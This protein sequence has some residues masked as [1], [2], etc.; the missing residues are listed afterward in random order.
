[1]EQVEGDNSVPRPPRPPFSM[2]KPPVSP[3]KKRTGIA[4]HMLSMFHLSAPDLSVDDY[5][6]PKRR[7]SDSAAIYLAEAN[8]LIA[9]PQDKPA[10]RMSGNAI[11]NIFKSK[12]KGAEAEGSANGDKPKRRNSETAANY[13]AQANALI[14]EPEDKPARRMVIGKLFKS[15]KKNIEAEDKRTREGSESGKTAKTK[16][17][18]SDTEGKSDEKPPNSRGSGSSVSRRGERKLGKETED[19]LIEKTPKSRGSGGSVSRRGE[20]KLGK[21]TEDDSIEK[22]SKGKRSGSRRKERKLGKETDDGSIENTPKSKKSAISV[23]CREDRKLGKETDD[24]SIE[25]TPKSKKSGFS[26]S[27]RGE[28]K[29]GKEIEDGS[30]GKIPTS[31][32]SGSSKEIQRERGT[33]D[34]STAESPKPQRNSGIG[35]DGSIRLPIGTPKSKRKITVP[36]ATAKSKSSKDGDQTTSTKKKVLKNPDK[37]KSLSNSASSKDTQK[38]KLEL[39]MSGETASTRESK[40]EKSE[41]STNSPGS[42]GS[43]GPGKKKVKSRRAGRTI[44]EEN[45]KRQRTSSVGA[46]NK[47]KF[48]KKKKKQERRRSFGDND[49]LDGLSISM[50]DLMSIDTDGDTLGTISLND[51]TLGTL[52][53]NDADPSSTT[54]QSTLACDVPIAAENDGFTSVSKTI[55]ASSLTLHFAKEDPADA[56]AK[57]DFTKRPPLR[58]RSSLS[59]MD[60]TRPEMM[61]KPARRNSFGDEGDIQPKEEEVLESNLRK[62]KKQKRG[63]KTSKKDTKKQ[64]AFTEDETGHRWNTQ[65]DV[66]SDAEPVRMLRRTLST[67]E[68]EGLKRDLLYNKLEVVRLRQSLSEA[69]DKAIKYSESQRQERKEFTK[70]TSELMQLKME[71]QKSVEERSRLKA[72]LDIYKDSLEEKDEK[73]D[74]LTGAVDN[75]LNKVELLEEELEH[76]E[77]DL[78]KMEDQI[79]EF[80]EAFPGID[81]EPAEARKSMKNIADDMDRKLEENSRHR[82][83]EERQDMLDLKEQE[84]D[85]KERMLELKLTSEKDG[86]RSQGEV[87]DQALLDD[88]V[89]DMVKELSDENKKLLGELVEEK[90]KASAQVRM[91]DGTQETLLREI[92][93]M[94]DK[95]Q[96]M[97][98]QVDSNAEEHNLVVKASNQKLHGLI[99]ENSQ[100]MEKLELQIGSVDV[101]EEQMKEKDTEISDLTTDIEDLQEELAKLKREKKKAAIRGSSDLLVKIASLKKVNVSLKEQLEA[102]K[103]ESPNSL[104]DESDVIATLKT[105]VSRLQL[106][107]ASS[108]S[109]NM[110]ILESESRLKDKLASS[111]TLRDSESDRMQEAIDKLLVENKTLEEEMKDGRTRTAVNLKKKDDTIAELQAQITGLKG[112]VNKNSSSASTELELQKSRFESL[113]VELEEAKAGNTLLRGAMKELQAHEAKSSTL[114][115][116]QKSDSEGLKAKVDEWKSKASSLQEKVKDSASQVADW[117]RRSQEWEKEAAEWESVA[118]GAQ[119]APTARVPPQSMYLSAASAGKKKED[120]IG[121][122]SLSNMFSRHSDHPRNAVN[123]KIEEDDERVEMLETQNTALKETLTKLQCQL[124][125]TDGE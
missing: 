15:K 47:E 108:K 35:M 95:L 116:E 32:G 62:G 21:E 79:R 20:R 111:Q 65:T 89:N 8:G 34:S 6:K 29:L 107:L 97:Q 73:I 102:E 24:G 55:K 66:R 90:E 46:I 96:L 17:K 86:S 81:G 61:E 7:N 122:G 80:E 11:G 125:E 99:D 39:T 12:K 68:K 119:S 59:A 23:S 45:E 105:K 27:C 41:H 123:A 37:S 74:A 31:R 42:L 53:L 117:K 78:F 43:K 101:V 93:I 2:G 28:R 9:E 112:A 88:H 60:V 69:L 109:V 118:T 120:A 104:R 98:T 50:P 57:P 5:D 92:D 22:T 82:R 100:L 121:W 76:A 44:N 51:A 115:D 64:V 83:L 84:L 16:N 25:N 106:D 13:E 113:Q 4:K 30:T 94:K 58:R 33:D 103:D 56:G 14:T 40:S 114:T 26:V 85:A 110:K 18:S 91:K 49:A 75:Q 10:R 48:R 52:P 63:K 54:Q 70:A 87:K 19:D 3:L 124:A 36:S 38:N 71:H 1:M 77:D 72:D 67:K